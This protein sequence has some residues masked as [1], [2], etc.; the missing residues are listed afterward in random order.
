MTKIKNAVMKYH[1]LPVATGLLAVASAFPAF[2]SETSS[3]V[4]A[5]DWAPVITELTKQVN[6]ST[7]I[8][9]LATFVAA[10]I[11]LCFMWWGLRKGLRSLMAAFRKGKLSV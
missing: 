8:A 9:A 1:A 11:G 2:A 7:I 6:V 5:S 10:G 4:S 3:T